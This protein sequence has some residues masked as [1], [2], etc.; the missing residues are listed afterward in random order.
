MPGGHHATLIPVPEGEMRFVS[1]QNEDME[2]R[3]SDKVMFR[4]AER[5]FITNFGGKIKCEI[6]GFHVEDFEN[7]FQQ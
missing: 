2:L 5:E 3:F 7:I 6:S 4:S 1:W